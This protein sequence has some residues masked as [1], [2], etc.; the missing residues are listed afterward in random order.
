MNLDHLK[1]YIE[2]VSTGNFSEVAKKLG[3]SQP[4]VSFQIQKLEQDLG[5]R[6]I[7]R[8]Q[9]KLTLTEPGKLLLSFAR[10]VQD[11]YSSML[12]DINHLREDVIGNLLIAASTIPGDFILP[13]LLSE[14]KTLHPSV[15]IQ[16]VVS[17]SGQ[18]IE[19]V[20][21]GTYDVGFCGIAPENKEI[22]AVKIAEDEIV[23]II[24][25]GHPFAGRTSVSFMEITEEPFI[26]REENSGTQ[27]NVASL[28]R[29]AG[30]DINLCKPSLILGTTEA[31]VSAVESQS[32][33]AF[34]SNYAIKKSLS[35]GMVETVNVEG[36][37]LKRDFYCIYRKERVVSRL[38]DEFISF[39]KAVRN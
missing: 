14:F 4:A 7:D 8:K 24:A 30:F 22:E 26:A 38:L 1:T 21:N 9:K 10:K 36:L 12:E 19:D 28:L 37:T 27:K 31:V 32:G 35:L 34:V 13:P 25:A 6:L 20:E 5:V 15:Q 11:E 16:V 23:L 29:K 33:I 17:D 18:V 39:I 2:V 3:I